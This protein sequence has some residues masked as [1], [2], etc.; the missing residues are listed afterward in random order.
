MVFFS[1]QSL[2]KAAEMYR[3]SYIASFENFPTTVLIYIFQIATF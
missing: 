2:F 3:I 1:P